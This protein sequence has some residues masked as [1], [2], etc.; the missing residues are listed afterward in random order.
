LYL[1]SILKHLFK[2]K[3][4]IMK[5][6]LNWV[7]MAAAGTMSGWN[8][9]AKLTED[10]TSELGTTADPGERVPVRTIKGKIFEGDGLVA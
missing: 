3:G 8:L 10:L 4:E 7:V 9:A 2:M 5:T 1:A 6:N